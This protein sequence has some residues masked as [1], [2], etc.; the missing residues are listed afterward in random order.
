MG[1]PLG[2][3]A[4]WFSLTIVHAIVATFAFVVGVT[5]WPGFGVFG[6]VFAWLSLDSY[7]GYKGK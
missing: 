3:K 6:L 4:T 1:D 7:R 5:V 2:M